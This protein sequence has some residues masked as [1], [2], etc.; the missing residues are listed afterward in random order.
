[1]ERIAASSEILRSLAERGALCLAA[2]HDGEL[3]NFLEDWY[4]QYHCT[5]KV[6]RC[7]RQQN[8]SR[9]RLGKK[10]RAR[11]YT[12]VFTFVL[13]YDIMQKKRQIAIER[14]GQ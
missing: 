2:T 4:E 1:M 8:S 6:L 3:C 12:P 9:N 7:S 10:N 13:Q 14:R 11:G 5:E